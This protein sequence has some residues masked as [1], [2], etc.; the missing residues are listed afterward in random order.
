LLEIAQSTGNNEERV[1]R[2]KDLVAADAS[3]GTERTDRTRYLAATASIELAEPVR[4]RFEAVRLTQPLD[5]SVKVKRRHMQ[6]VLKAYTTA[7][8]YGVAEVVTEATYRLAG[9]YEHFAKALLESERPRDLDA[10]ALEQYELLLE[11]QVFP[12]EEQA[13]D[14][15]VTNTDRTPKGVYDEWV[16]KS[17]D[18]LAG[19]MPARYAKS[20]RSED[21]VTSFY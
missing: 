6:E 20:E 1:A 19:L 9:V 14:L 2:L 12:F 3:A 17:F 4:Q 15:Y 18:R 5:E 11:E 8:D 16:Q 13:I 21:V 10:L 7:A